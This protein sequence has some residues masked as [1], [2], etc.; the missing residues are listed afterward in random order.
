MAI[1]IKVSGQTEK[2][3]EW[4]FSWTQMVLCTKAN[5]KMIN[6]MDLEQN[7]GTT[8]R[9][10]L[11]VILSKVRRP[12]KVDSNLKVAIMKV[13]SLMDSSMELANI[14]LP[15]RADFMKVNSRIIIWKAKVK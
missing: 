8:T 6:N 11:L 9:S 1:F 12:V 4:V 3:M 14:T 15:T 13:I 5:G 10:S 7:H 2:Q